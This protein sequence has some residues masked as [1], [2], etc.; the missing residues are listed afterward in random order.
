VSPRFLPESL[1]HE[2]SR[3]R[4][5]SPSR[6]PGTLPLRGRQEAIAPQAHRAD[7]VGGGPHV[8]RCPAVR[9]ARTLGPP[10]GGTDAPQAHRGDP[11]GGGPQDTRCPAERGGENPWSPRRGDGCAA[12]AQG[13]HGR[14][15]PTRYA[16]PVVHPLTGRREALAPQAHRGDPVG[17]GPQDTRYP[18]ERGGENPLVPPKGGRMRRRRTGGT[19]SAAA[20]KIRAAGGPPADGEARG[21]C[22]AGAQGGYGRRRSTRYALPVVHPLTGRREALAPQAHRGD[23]VGGGPQDTRCRWPSPSVTS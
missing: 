21:P 12:G 14:R 9:E 3:S 11:V 22:A 4:L 2:G 13:G 23:P 8:A 1:N 6:P 10:E 18:A 16:L 19:Q 5:P 20:H 17:G 7:A 15:R